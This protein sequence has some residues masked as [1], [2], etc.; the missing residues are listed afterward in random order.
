[1][2][3]TVDC[4]QNNILYSSSRLL[5]I[6]VYDHIYS[7]YVIYIVKTYLM[8]NEPG[9]E[10]RFVGVFSQRSLVLITDDVLLRLYTPLQ[11]YE[12][13]TINIFIMLQSSSNVSI[14]KHLLI[15]IY[16]AMLPRQSSLYHTFSICTSQCVTVMW[17]TLV[18]WHKPLVQ[19]YWIS[20]LSYL[21]QRTCNYGNK[22]HCLV[23]FHISWYIPTPVYVSWCLVN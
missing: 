18:F 15:Y 19:V 16:E 21:R 2:F 11:F 7:W 9:K 10:M 13:L 8:V 6:H 4:I 12:Y 1:M 20:N 17:P 22:Y 23:V 3:W 5:N 14:L